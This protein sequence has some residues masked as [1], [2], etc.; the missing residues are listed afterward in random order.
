MG[1]LDELHMHFCEIQTNNQLNQHLNNYDQ[2][3]FSRFNT[4]QHYE[5]ILTLSLACTLNHFIKTI[6]SDAMVDT[7]Q[8]FHSR[9]NLSMHLTLRVFVGNE[10]QTDSPFYSDLVI[11][12]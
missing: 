9:S 1:S 10:L 5:F 6:L 3:L 11:L 7:V 4:N 2:T 8:T 12:A